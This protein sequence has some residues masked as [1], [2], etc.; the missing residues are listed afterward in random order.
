MRL[1]YCIFLTILGCS[2]GRSTGNQ[3]IGTTV[4]TQGI[5]R[6]RKRDTYE[7]ITARRSRLWNC[8]DANSHAKFVVHKPTHLSGAEYVST[9]RLKSR[10]QLNQLHAMLHLQYHYYREYASEYASRTMGTIPRG[11]DE[12][13]NASCSFVRLA[14]TFNPFGI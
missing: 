2:I 4:L 3:L 14:L 8:G 6:T 10:Q 7:A 13:L 12:D 1:M 11:Q 5:R 9:S